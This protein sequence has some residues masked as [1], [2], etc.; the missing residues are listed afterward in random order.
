MVHATECVTCGRSRELVDGE[1][2]YC[3]ELTEQVVD[4]YSFDELLVQAMESDDV[5]R[6]ARVGR[7][8]GRSL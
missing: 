1:C 3:R 2:V 5:E 8:R 7:V 4:Q 6:M